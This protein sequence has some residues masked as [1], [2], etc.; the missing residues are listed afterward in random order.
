MSPSKPSLNL[1]FIPLSNRVP[2]KLSPTIVA[3]G[4][5]VDGKQTVNKGAIAGGVVSG[6]V[7]TS[8][9]IS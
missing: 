4:T 1:A 3:N 7:V 5:N 9:F 8:F 6:I 2:V